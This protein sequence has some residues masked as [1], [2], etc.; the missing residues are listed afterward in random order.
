MSGPDDP[1]ARHEPPPAPSPFEL[2][3]LAQ[4]VLDAAKDR[5]LTVAVAE[6]L[7]GGQLAAAFTAVPGASAV[8]RGSVTAYATDLKASILGV[9]CALLAEVGAVHP[10]VARGMA[11][12]VRRVCGADLGLATTG[13]AG[14]DPQDGKPVGTVYVAVAG[15]ERVEVEYCDFGAAPDLGSEGR[16]RI[17]RLSVVAVLQL[18]LRYLGMRT[19]S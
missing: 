3:H 16:P 5:G 12:G 6:S 7:T 17:Q 15:Q 13:V 10:E 4:R 11:Q 9:D 18:T 19:R 14:P 1:A 8:F 2:A